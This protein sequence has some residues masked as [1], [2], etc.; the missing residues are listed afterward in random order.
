MGKIVAIGGGNKRRTRFS[1][2]ALEVDQEIIKLS[3]K[4]NPISYNSPNL[5]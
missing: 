2:E 3:K 4:S 5:S 1:V